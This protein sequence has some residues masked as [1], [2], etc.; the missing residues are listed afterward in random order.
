MSAQQNILRAMVQNVF[1]LINRIQNIQDGQPYVDT[2]KHS[3]PRSQRASS[4]D[5]LHPGYTTSHCTPPPTSV[6]FAGKFPAVS[7]RILRSC[8]G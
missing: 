3:S 7:P 2:T 8:L 4:P 5:Q 1:Y 6:S